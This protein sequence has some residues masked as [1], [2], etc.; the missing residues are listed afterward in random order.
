MKHI[1][2]G[3]RA[4]GEYIKNKVIQ[5]NMS[6]L[7]DEAKQPMEQ[8]SFVVKDE[9]GKIFGGVTGTMYF[10]HLHIDF[11]GLMIQFVMM[12]MVVNYYIKLKILRRKKVVD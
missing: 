10:Y 11:Y 7:T 4:E 1:E 2:N 8:V 3:T 6:I 9:A 12:V 5:Y